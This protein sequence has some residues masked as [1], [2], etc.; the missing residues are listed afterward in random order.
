MVGICSP[1]N[2]DDDKNCSDNAVVG[3]AF[4]RPEEPAEEFPSKEGMP[5][6]DEVDKRDAREPGR[7]G[8]GVLGVW[9][10]VFDPF[11]L[12]GGTDCGTVDDGVGL[13]GGGLTSA[14]TSTGA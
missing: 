10:R 4:A 6:R 2:G 1:D 9:P 14:G 3:A 5:N 7:S 8:D 13:L 11:E 12:G